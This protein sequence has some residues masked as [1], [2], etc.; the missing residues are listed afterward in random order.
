MSVFITPSVSGYKKF[1]FDQSQP[2][3]SLTKFLKK[4]LTFSTQDKFNMKIYS[5][6]DLMKLI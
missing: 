3:L 4:V 6:I 5:T 1:D 2:A